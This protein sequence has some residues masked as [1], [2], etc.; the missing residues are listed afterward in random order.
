MTITLDVMGFITRD[1]FIDNSVDTV[2]PF[3]ELSD[4]SLTFSKNRRTYYD[5]EDTKYSIHVF[6]SKNINPVTQ[7]RTEANL[8]NSK[9]AYVVKAY[10]TFVDMLTQNPYLT[11]AQNIQFGIDAIMANSVGNVVTSINYMDIAEFR[12]LRLPDKFII[13]LNSNELYTIW[14]SDILFQNDYPQYEIN[15]VTQTDNFAS[16][17]NSPSEMIALLNSFNLVEFNTRIELNKGLHPTT[18]TRILNIPYRIPSTSTYKDC[19]FGFNIYGKEGDYNDILK[20]ELLAYLVDGSGLTESQVIA[21]FPDIA[22]INEFFFVPRWD[23]V[24]IPSGVAQRGIYSQILPTFT[25]AIDLTKF[26]KIYTPTHFNTNSYNVPFRYNNIITV[27]VNGQFTDPLVKDFLSYYSDLITVNSLS[28][29]FGRMRSKTQHLI[30]IMDYLLAL[31][32]KDDLLELY[33]DVTYLNT[34]QNTYRF[35]VRDRMGIKYVVLR[36]DIHTYYVI[37]KFEY[38]RVM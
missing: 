17:I 12:G 22:K 16:I 14:C 3:L 7:V 6:Y 8:L 26:I 34:T 30:T 37:P 27:A 29:D 21:L 1:D 36:Y 19:Y 28:T 13:E 9:M 38:V 24:A 4:N 18:Y 32:E 15:I 33:N 2:N 11:K 10:R 31:A 35:K 23:K 5:T 25:D 20:N